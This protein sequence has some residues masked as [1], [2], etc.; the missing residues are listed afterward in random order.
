M[1]VVIEVSGGVVVNVMGADD[2]VIVDWDAIDE[3]IE[4]PELP[5]GYVYNEYECGVEEE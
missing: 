1:S 2:Y 3:G 5:K 4:K